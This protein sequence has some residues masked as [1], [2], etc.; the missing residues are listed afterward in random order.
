MFDARRV[1]KKVGLVI[2]EKQEG[3]TQERFVFGKFHLPDK[4]YLYTE[5]IEKTERVMA[6]QNL[7]PF[8]EGAML[9]DL[10]IAHEIFHSIE[11]KDKKLYTSAIRVPLWRFLGFTYQSG[12]FAAGEIAAMDFAREITGIS[13]NPFLFDILLLY[14]K[15]GE[16][17]AKWAK[18]VLDLCPPHS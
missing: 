6:D 2:K 9:K 4:I 1:C 7:C 5:N 13:Y 3:D 8:F 11:L 10:I 18:K 14:M 17:G 15:D 16:Y 12:L